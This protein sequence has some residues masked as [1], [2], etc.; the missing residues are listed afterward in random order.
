MDADVIVIGAGFA[1]VA[2]ARDLI[3]AGHRVV[4]LEARDRIGGRTWYRQIPDTEV[5]AEYGG[6]F[7]SRETQPSLAAE[8]TRYGI[9]VTEPGEPETIGWVRGDHREEGVGAI[10]RI[11]EQLSHSSLTDAL[12]QT[13]K[14]FASEGREALAQ[15]DVP[16]AG[17]VDGLHAP[18][19]AADYLRSFLAAMGGAKVEKT[20][21]LPL[22]WDMIELEYTPVDAYVDLGELITDG[23]KALIDA[24]AH[25][26]DIRSGSVVASVS[27]DDRG[28][29]VT[30]ADGSRLEA[31][32]AIVALPINVWADVAFDPPLA[33]PKQRA[34]SERHPGE[35]SKVIAIVRGAPAGYLGAG[36]DT[37]VNAGFVPKPSDGEQLFMGFSVQDRVDLSDDTAMTDA[38]HAHVPDAKVVRTT[39]H[40]WITDPFSR[41]TW[42]AVPPTWFSD[43][44][45]D[46]LREPEGRLLFAGSDIAGEGAGWI[47]GAVGSGREAASVAAA[48]LGRS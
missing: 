41:G 40:D 8:L 42:L 19:E 10:D 20:S 28:V 25:G 4:V 24:M 33:A 30:L 48:L 21:I 38:V 32:A 44:T 46:Q 23:T 2:A 9:G 16:S 11:R 47:E 36:W 26:L 13:A 1:G 15:L 37:S 6:M 31:P 18:E 17:W 12:D 22:L 7:I 5:W 3:E 43:G 14:A 29:T 45:F 39:G 27:T 34:A 35:V